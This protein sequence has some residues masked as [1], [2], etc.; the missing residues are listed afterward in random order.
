[1]DV[2]I[3]ERKV[4]SQSFRQERTVLPA[5]R[6]G[7]HYLQNDGNHGVDNSCITEFKCVD[8]NQ[9]VPYLVTE[10]SDFNKKQTAD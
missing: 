6:E 7:G 1:M 3:P 9:K 2:G 4:L 10:M 5:G 8:L